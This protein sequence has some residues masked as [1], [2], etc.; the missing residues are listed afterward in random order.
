MKKTTMKTSR[1]VRRLA[2]LLAILL[3]LSVGTLAQKAPA[4]A[5]RDT[6]KSAL[7]AGLA[8]AWLCMGAYAAGRAVKRR[9][10]VKRQT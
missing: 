7:L 3:T 1:A 9:H 4:A 10:A 6:L 5:P 8:G 2:L